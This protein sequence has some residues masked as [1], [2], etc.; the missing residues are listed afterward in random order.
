MNLLDIL[1]KFQISTDLGHQLGSQATGMAVLHILVMIGLVMIK[2]GIGVTIGP[3][4]CPDR[5]RCS[6]TRMVCDAVIPQSAPNYTKEV[7]L[8]ELHPKYLIQNVFCNVSWGSVNKLVIVFSGKWS[9]RAYGTWIYLNDK[10]FRCL[11]QIESLKVTMPYLVSFGQLFDGLE[12]VVEL[13]FS[14]STRFNT[15]GL[16]ET[17]SLNSSFPKLSRLIL[18]GTGKVFGGID[19]SQKLIDLLSYRNI[20]ELEISFTSVTAAAT[21][22]SGICDTIKKLNFSHVFVKPSKSDID[23]SKPCTS[24]ITVDASGMDILKS[25]AHQGPY[26][27]TDMHLDFSQNPLPQFVSYIPELYLNSIAISNLN[28]DDIIMSNTSLAVDCIDCIFAWSAIHFSGYSIPIFD[29][30]I[31]IPYAPLE[32][33]DF[34]RNNVES[35]GTNV[36]KHLQKLT[37]IDL[38]ENKLA[39]TRPDIFSVLFKYNTGLQELNLSENKLNS[40]PVDTLVSNIKLKKLDMSRNMFKQL[41]VDISQ[42]LKLEYLDLSHNMIE[43]LDEQSI[44]SLDT[45]Y[46]KQVSAGHLSDKNATFALDLRGNPFSCQCPALHFLQWFI[47][48]SLFNTTRQDYSCV[49][50]NDTIPMNVEAVRVAIDDCEAPIRRRRKIV[51]SVTIPITTMLLLSA[52]TILLVQKRRRMRYYRRMEYQLDMIHGNTG[53]F[54]FPVF[55]SYSSEDD[56]FAIG[57]VYQPLQ[58]LL[59]EYHLTRK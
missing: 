56:E 42:L 53:E 58:V 5:C 51:L 38:S 40:L 13:D 36:F 47:Q 54:R 59:D 1:V 44:Q 34:S 17:L 7:T 10:A 15:T 21:D 50:H 8:S 48:T 3:S 28:S 37:N 31:K 4:D 25:N 45:L 39:A 27:L 33:I 12:N 23:Y 57:K 55:L 11:Q 43:Y 24:L 14:G 18:S 35:I 9:D 6:G 29:I 46:E 41:T 30:D 20:T 16:V 32:T 26:N 52:V 49:F 19:I 22:I 2:S